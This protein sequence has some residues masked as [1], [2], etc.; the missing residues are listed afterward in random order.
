MRL[1][2][3]NFP[4][5]KFFTYIA[6]AL[7]YS[8]PAWFSP[9]A[10]HAQAFDQLN[11]SQAGIEIPLAPAPSDS[12]RYTA[13]PGFNVYFLSVGQGDSIYMELPGGQNALIDGGPSD[14]ASGALAAFLSVKNITKIDHVVLTHPHAD[15]YKGLLYVFSAIT[16][17][18]FYDT[19]M[20]NDSAS[21]DNTL[22]A[23]VLAREV[24]TFYP[25]P[26][27]QLAWG[28]AAVKVFNSCPEPV[29]SSKGDVVN[30][31]SIVLKL[32]YQN[33]SI[34]FTGDMQDEVE[35]VLVARFGAELKADVLKV[36]HHGSQYSTSGPFLKAVS[37]ERAYIEVGRNNYGHPT[38]PAL[39]RL[40]AAG[41]RIFRTDLD[42]TMQYSLAA[43]P[44]AVAGNLPFSY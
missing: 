41:A 17:G 24:P 20:E 16:V 44:L 40:L 39:S 7:V 35:A 26:G 15:H 8:A 38:Q 4:G 23:M 22:R 34:L 9:S 3:N 10:L 18:N 13:A 28:G 1:V 5:L 11:A 31:C 27:D 37:P 6:A 12:T 42:G 25:S 29:H 32:A 33:S 19:R 2:N 36:G 14:S 43:A 30:N 21:G